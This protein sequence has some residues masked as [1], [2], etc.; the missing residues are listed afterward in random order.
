MALENEFLDTVKG[1]DPRNVEMIHEKV[2]WDL[3]QRS[4]T[5]VVSLG[6]SAL[7]IA[8]WDIRGKKEGRTEFH[9]ALAFSEN[10]GFGCKRRHEACAQGNGAA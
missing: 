4:M 7:D 8:C 6:L 2:W 3:N 9:S 1:L 5:G 10:V